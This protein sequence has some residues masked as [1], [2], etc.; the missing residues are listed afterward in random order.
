VRA[1]SSV[2]DLIPNEVEKVD[3]TLAS[4]HRFRVKCHD[5]NDFLQERPW[6]SVSTDYTDYADK[7][8]RKQEQEAGA[9]N[10]QV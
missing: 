2:L 7:R 8:I 6:R 3:E 9:V 5:L 4:F 1:R 10:R